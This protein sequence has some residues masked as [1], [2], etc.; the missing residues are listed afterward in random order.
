MKTEEIKA[1][2]FKWCTCEGMHI[3]IDKAVEIV[4]MFLN[5]EKQEI[6][7][8]S[9]SSGNVFE[10]K[11]N[12]FLQD[13]WQISSTFCGYGHFAILIKTIEHG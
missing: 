13:G 2:L 9:E 12:E 3:D 11:V 4:E 1:E 7:L 10:D 5:K 8:V 6:R